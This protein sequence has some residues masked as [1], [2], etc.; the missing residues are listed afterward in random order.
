MLLSPPTQVTG[1]S[2]FFGTVLAGPQ[3]SAIVTHLPV[4]KSLLDH[5]F[6]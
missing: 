2:F 4:T 1:F 6:L 3:V 5:A